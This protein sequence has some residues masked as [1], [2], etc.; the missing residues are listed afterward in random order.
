MPKDLNSLKLQKDEMSF[1][2]WNQLTACK[3]KDGWY[4]FV[5]STKHVTIW[6]ECRV[7]RVKP[8]YILD[9]KI[10]KTRVDRNDQLVSY[11]LFKTKTM[12]TVFF[13]AFKRSIVNTKNIVHEIQ[14]FKWKNAFGRIHVT[15]WWRK[16]S[17]L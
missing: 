10:N 6:S 2:H 17:K 15:N 12:R 5:F 3:W 11:H 14:T 16:W 13:Y 1:W 4:V 7:D 9:D 8:D